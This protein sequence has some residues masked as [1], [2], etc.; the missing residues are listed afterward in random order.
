MRWAAAVVGG[1][2]ALGAP[3]SAADDA[4]F[5]QL[6]VR[7]QT[8]SDWHPNPRYSHDGR[9]AG[10]VQRRADD[11]LEVKVENVYTYYSIDVEI[12]TPKQKQTLLID[13]GSSDIWVIGSEN[14]Y[15]ASTPKEKAQAAM[16]VNYIDCGG[17]GTFNLSD[18]SSFRK[19]DT[20]FFIQYGD[21]SFAKGGWGTDVLAFAGTRVPAVSFAV[22]EETN[23]SQGVFGIGLQGLES[24]VSNNDGA[25]DNLPLQLRNE[26][27]IAR[28]AYSLWLNDIQS[29]AGSLLFGGVDHAKYSGDLQKVPI[30]SNVDKKGDDPVEMTV[31]LSG[32]GIKKNTASKRDHDG[33]AE[34]IMSSNVPVLLDSGTSLVLLPDAV[35]RAVGRATGAEY[36]RELGYYVQECGAGDGGAA[37]EFDFSGLK[38]DVALA[39]LLLP[40]SDGAGNPSQFANGKAAC[41]LG[42]SEATDT[43][44]L[45]DTFLRSA[46][47][48]YD[49]ENHEIAM[50]PVKYNQTK[51]DIETIKSD[52]PKAKKAPRY[53]STKLAQTVS[54]NSVDQALSEV[55]SQTLTAAN[56]VGF[57]G[58]QSTQQTVES[59]LVTGSISS[60]SRDTRSNIWST[61]SA[62]P[63]SSNLPTSSESVS[64]SSSSSSASASSATSASSSSSNGAQQQLPCLLAAALC[65]LLSACITC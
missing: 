41:A 27:K 38:I 19:N 49:L 25:Y 50:A 10:V 4:G 17:S 56:N 44:I 34:S 15:C 21:Y 35:L 7:G 31:V 26:G 53:S 9:Y 51:S 29:R 47:V 40:L 16:G 8:S 45:G 61:V 28:V 43:I 3:A 62:K 64:S 60:I 65:I 48:V 12:G 58:A 2:V 18:S 42:M 11:T 1:L 37:L 54:L 22:G 63:T 30:V 14:P 32:L 5:V 39:D 55:K 6:E 46:Y 33:A 20:D 36:S 57:A 24:T 59:S 13:T 52:I 23:S